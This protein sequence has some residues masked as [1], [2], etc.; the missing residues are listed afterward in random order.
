MHWHLIAILL[1]NSAANAMT[2]PITPD[3]LQPFRIEGANIRGRIARLSASYEGIL[4]AHAYPEPVARVLGE[5]IA[6]TAAIS[7]SLKFDGIFYLQTQSNGSIPM[8]VADVTSAGQMRGYARYNEEAF[9]G[10]EE[11]EQ[12]LPDLLGTGHLAFTLDQGVHTERYQGIVAL[13]GNTIAECAQSYFQ[14]SE[15]LDTSI[16]V[17]AQP[18][19]DDFPA[20]A[21]IIMIQ[22]MPGGE[23]LILTADEEEENWRNATILLNSLT[24]DELLDPRLSIE[25]LL[26]R[27]FHEKGVRVYDKKEVFYQCRCA[28]EKVAY[29]LA[30]FSTEDLADMK[31]NNGEITATC[32]FCGTVYSFNDADLDEI[33]ALESRA[34]STS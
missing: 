14:Q 27:L 22:K 34:S 8:L 19:A 12:T 10:G 17:A 4:G 31:I 23:R 13:E 6:L 30:A 20:R 5:V 25:K 32:E 18:V 9:I 26:Y 15:Q 7:T 21:A 2:R 16:I 11:S 1:H 33:R 29:T 28:R 24:N 3:I